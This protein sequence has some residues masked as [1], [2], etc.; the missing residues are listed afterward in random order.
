MISTSPLNPLIAAMAVC[1]LAACATTPPSPPP[2]TSPPPQT[3]PPPPPPAGQ[4]S[5]DDASAAASLP[6]PAETAE[7]SSASEAPQQPS[8]PAQAAQRALTDADAAAGARGDRAQP[9]TANARQGDTPRQSQGLGAQ[10]PQSPTRPEGAAAS[11]SG[12]TAEERMAA[13]DRDFGDSLGSF[14]ERLAR[15]QF[16]L[17]QQREAAAADQAARR[18][19]AAGSSGDGRG[20]GGMSMPPPPPSGGFE[21]DE[22]DGAYDVAQGPSGRSSPGNRSGLPVPDDVG[23]GR[24]DDIVARQL[25]EAAER[26]TDPELRERLWDEYREYKRSQR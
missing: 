18:A 9:A 16:D 10:D 4:E 15:E 3:Q 6:Q 25:R 20:Q 1:L 5:A 17:Q 24:N 14:D 23:D 2:P 21:G 11:G 13:L 26:E 12:M 8:P 22:E 7:G 19:A